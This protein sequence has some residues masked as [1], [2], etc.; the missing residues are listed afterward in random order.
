V[1]TTT[2]TFTFHLILGTTI[3]LMQLK[4][5]TELYKSAISVI[6]NKHHD[7]TSPTTGVV[8]LH[9]APVTYVH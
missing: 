5:R 1:S 9:I 7:L 8:V 3:I 4:N 2:D 6:A